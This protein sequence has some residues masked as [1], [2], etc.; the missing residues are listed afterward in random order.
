MLTLSAGSPAPPDFVDDAPT[1]AAAM[2]AGLTPPSRH[3]PQPFASRAAC[4][5]CAN[6][7]ARARPSLIEDF[8]VARPTARAA[9]K[10]VH[11]LA[12]HVDRTLGDLWK[13]AGMPSRRALL[14][15]GGYGRAELF[16]H[17][18][19]DVLVLLP[20]DDPLASAEVRDGRRGLHHR[21][22][23][24]RA[25]D[26]LVG[27]HA[28]RVP[29]RVDSATSP[30]RP[31]CSSRAGSAASRR[32]FDAFNEAHRAAIDPRAFLRAK[33]LEMRQRHVKYE[34]TPYSL[35][36]NCKESPGG[37]RDLQVVIWVARAAGLGRT[38]AELA[39][40]GLITPFEVAAAAAQRGHAA[41]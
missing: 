12:R 18:D 29:G 16:P 5:R 4:R 28:R 15:V 41:R 1:R 35:E 23:G 37:L 33:T 2:T 22:L 17:S 40:N 3:G 30:C 25:G 24:H 8:R 32:L 27:A 38:W 10:L 21:L 7:S 19:V 26:R 13:H 34:G 14:A 36:P 9:R 39:A 20:G 11:D 6:S 31:R